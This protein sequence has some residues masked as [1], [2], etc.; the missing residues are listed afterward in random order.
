MF[1]QAP[2]NFQRVKKGE[3]A[4]KCLYERR[5]SSLLFASPRLRSTEV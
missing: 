4:A 1:Q 2:I 5:V 3:H